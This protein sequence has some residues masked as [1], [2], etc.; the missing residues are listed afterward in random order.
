MVAAMRKPILLLLLLVGLGGVGLT[1]AMRRDGPTSRATRRSQ[2]PPRP[3]ST[4]PPAEPVAAPSGTPPATTPNSAA[5][6]HEASLETSKLTA[7]HDPRPAVDVRRDGGLEFLRTLGRRPGSSASDVLTMLQDDEFLVELFSGRSDGPLA[8]GPD[9]SSERW[10]EGMVLEYPEG[11]FE[12]SWPPNGFVP[13]GM[14]IRGA[15]IDRTLLRLK[16]GALKGKDLAALSLIDLTIQAHNSD[17]FQVGMATIRID[18]CR[19]ACNQQVIRGGAVVL[20][21]RACRFEGM[22]R[23]LLDAEG[24]ARLDDC[25]F[26]GKADLVRGRATYLF[27]RCTF[28]DARQDLAG[29]LRRNHPSVYLEACVFDDRHFAGLQLEKINPTWRN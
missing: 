13:S 10:S 5:P 26:W 19:V 12:F 4:P 2:E 1:I 11:A 14:V 27:R 28:L 24:L 9:T 22:D 20:H 21:A 15:G 8:S 29:L 23:P 6:P 7:S 18:R 25:V 16:G 17:L 3:I